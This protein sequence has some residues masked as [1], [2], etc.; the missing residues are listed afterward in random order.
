MK[1][2]IRDVL[3]ELKPEKFNFVEKYEILISIYNLQVE[4]VKKMELSNEL[5]RDLDLQFKVFS[6]I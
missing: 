1:D 6:K 3:K 2:L 5:P 4:N